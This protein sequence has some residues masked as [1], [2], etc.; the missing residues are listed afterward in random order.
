MA[1]CFVTYMNA[2]F[3][4]FMCDMKSTFKERNCLCHTYECVTNTFYVSHERHIQGAQLAF[5]VTHM[6]ASY[7]RSDRVCV[8][9]VHT[10]DMTHPLV[11]RDTFT[12]CVFV[13]RVHTCGTSLWHTYRGL[14]N[15]MSSTLQSY[16]SLGACVW[17]AC[18]YVIQLIH[19]FDLFSFL[20]FFARY[21]CVCVCECVWYAFTCVIQLI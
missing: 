5:H 6:N 8:W 12:R 9:R 21:V 1:T 16:S 15:L 18:T 2:S 17:Y 20:A 14:T 13:M 19:W 11:C 10:C 7:P 4:H 3:T